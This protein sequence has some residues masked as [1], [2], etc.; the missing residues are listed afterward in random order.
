MDGQTLHKKLTMSIVKI[1]REYIL[2][3]LVLELTL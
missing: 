1:Q 3:V 2:V